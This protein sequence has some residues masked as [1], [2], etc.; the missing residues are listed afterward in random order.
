MRLSPYAL[1]IMF[2]PF[3]SNASILQVSGEVS[4]SWD[5]DTVQVTDDIL[6]PNNS[7]LTIDPGTKIFFDGHFVFKVAGQVLA[8][9]QENDPILFT[10]AD[11]TGFHDIQTNEGAWNG[12]WFD[13][14]SPN[15]DSTI[16]EHCNFEYGKAVGMDSTYWYGGAICIREFN[17]LRITNCTFSNNMAFKNGGA[18]YGKLANIKIEHC[19]FENNYAG[20]QQ[21]WGYGGGVCLEFGDAKIYRNYFI[22]NSST[23]VGG[24]LSF[25]YANPKIESNI[26]VDNYSA[27]GGGFCTLRSEAGNYIVNNL[28]ENNEALHFGGGVAFLESEVLFS[29][30]T[31]ANNY[32]TYGGGLYFNAEAMPTLKNCIVWGNVALS[33][34]GPQ[35][36][37]W[38]VFSAPVFY[39]CD[40]QDGL[41]AFSGSGGTA[42]IGIYEN[43]LDENPQFL[44]SGNFPYGLSENSPCV[45]SGTPDTTGL[46]LPLMDLAG[47]SRFQNE[48]LDMGAY[49][50]QGPVG[51]NFTKLNELSFQISPNPVEGFSEIS[52]SLNSPVNICFTLIS[53][54]G[55]ELFEIIQAHYGTGDHHVRID[56]SNIKQ[57]AYLLRARINNETGNRTFN[58]VLVR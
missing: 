44:E 29:N 18:V 48:Q 9:G 4:G 51:F 54:S 43:N 56:F 52:F 27:I 10:V 36:Y 25:E 55:E 22:Q 15:N 26:F 32:S 50:F 11:T 58:K 21:Y 31:V 3:I 30:N 28:V 47:N 12:F 24:G 40:I 14:L 19:T 2:I 57:G 16:F 13:H 34:E 35:V 38:D 37:I 6:V 7:F 41:E 42:F 49:E 23:G 20:T 8:S 46:M 39:Y 45:N 53:I 33:G 1:L 5:V 17:R